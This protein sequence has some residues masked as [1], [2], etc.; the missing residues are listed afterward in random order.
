MIRRFQLVD[1]GCV[2]DARGTL[3]LLAS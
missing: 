2:G 1:R 3:N